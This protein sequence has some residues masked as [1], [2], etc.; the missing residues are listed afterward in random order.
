M[1]PNTFDLIIKNPQSALADGIIL[2]FAAAFTILTLRVLWRSLR[3]ADAKAGRESRLGSLAWMAVVT[4]AALTANP[5]YSSKNPPENNGNPPGPCKQSGGGNPQSAIYH[6]PLPRT[7]SLTPVVGYMPEWWIHDDTCSAGDGIPDLWRKWTHTL[8]Y[9]WWEIPTTTGLILLESFWAQTDPLMLRTL[10]YAL[11]D[12]ELLRSGRNPLVRPAFFDY[13]N[14]Y[15][16]GVIDYFAINNGYLPDEWLYD[17]YTPTTASIGG[18]CLTRCP[19][20]RRTIMIYSL[21]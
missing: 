11:T 16:N 7:N 17:F 12:A 13:T 2:L 20:P 9:E 15:T 18:M 1:N 4:V 3:R 8:K 14:S 10:G 21:P 5:S 19:T 6:S